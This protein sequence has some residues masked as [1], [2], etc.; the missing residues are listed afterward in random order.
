[1]NRFGGSDKKNNLVLIGMPGAGKSTIGVIAAKVL[2]MR[3]V[4]ADILIQEREERLLSEI[5][6]QDGVEGFLRIEN[7]VNAGIEC[8]NSVIA[9]GGSVIYGREAMSHLRRIGTVVYLKL[10]HDALTE[11]LG[12]LKNRGVVLKDGQTFEDLYAERTPL[13]EQYAHVI[14]EED[15]LSMEETLEQVVKQWHTK[16]I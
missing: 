3:F 1:M 9:T 7:E 15:G 14:V 6:E 4:D 2:G 5:I 11:R 12:D 8:T 10:T 13:Y 16:N